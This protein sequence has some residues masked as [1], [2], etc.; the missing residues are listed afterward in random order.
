MT[1]Q[2]SHTRKPLAILAGIGLLVIGHSLTEDSP[3]QFSRTLPFLLMLILGEL[4]RE[5][6]VAR[7]APTADE[8]TMRRR[9]YH[10][11]IAL[12]AGIGFMALSVIGAVDEWW[13]R[14]GVWGYALFA[15]GM[16]G[17]GVSAGIMLVRSRTDAD[18]KL[19]E[20]ARGGQQPVSNA[21]SPLAFPLVFVVT[22]VIFAMANATAIDTLLSQQALN[23]R[24][25]IRVIVSAVLCGGLAFIVMRKL[26]EFADRPFDAANPDLT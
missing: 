15:A 23:S 20:M 1:T 26:N 22:L 11:W 18:A 3:A 24:Q 25:W 10:Q 8:R 5:W 12:I 2:R 13:P 21:L 4:V 7:L 17:L 14:R 6:T 16:I 9:R 19:A